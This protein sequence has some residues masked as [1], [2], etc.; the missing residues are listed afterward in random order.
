ME[1]SCHSSTTQIPFSCLFCFLNGALYWVISWWKEQGIIREPKVRK[2]DA[3]FA[4]EKTF[5]FLLFLSSRN[6]S[7]ENV[8][9]K[10]TKKRG[11]WISLFQSSGCREIPFGSTVCEV[12]NLKRINNQ[13]STFSKPFSLQNIINKWPYSTWSKAFSNKSPFNHF[14]FAISF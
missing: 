4:H 2:L 5:N 12:R 13:N 6:N 1:K 10:W 11:K 14:N 7:T 8:H 3:F 9:H